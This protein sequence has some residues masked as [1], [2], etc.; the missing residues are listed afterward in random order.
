MKN[1]FTQL[2]IGSVLVIGSLFSGTASAE[3]VFGKI[4]FV[5]TTGVEELNPGGHARFRM[6]VSQ[7]TCG[8]DATPKD[9]WI[10]VRSGRMDGEFVHNAANFKNTYS[11]LLVALLTNNNVQIDGVP[12]CDA[13]AQDI[14]L[15]DLWIGIF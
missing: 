14:D 12:S 8:A 5:G 15:K 9:R 10:G 4:T 2:V 1:T 11:T 13:P 6:R 3:T 7:S